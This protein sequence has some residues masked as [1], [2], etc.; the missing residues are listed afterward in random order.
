MNKNLLLTFAIL[1]VSLFA[2]AQDDKELITVEPEVE[3]VDYGFN[4]WSIELDL[5]DSKGAEPYST[6]YFASN[7][8]KFFGGVQLNH[9]GLAARYMVAPKIGMRT[10]L[11]YDM[12]QNQ[13][14]T[15]SK[16]F[17]T[18][19]IQMTFE[20]VV[21]TLR[22]F[23]VQNEAGRFGLLFHLGVEVGYMSPKEGDLSAIGHHEWNGGIVAGLTP[24]YRIFDDVSLFFDFTVNS[25]LRQHFTWNGAWAEGE[26]NLTGKMYTSSL[27]VS[28]GLGKGDV[29]G[30]WAI[31]EDISNKEV[32]ELNNRIGEIEDMMNDT[33]KDGVPDYLDVENNSIA[34][35]AVDTKGR[36]VDKNSNG[37][38]DEFEKFV[39]KTIT[40]NYNSNSNTVND[41]IVEKLINDGYIAAYFDTGKAEPTVASSDNIGF[42]LN[43]LKNNPK[44]SVEIIGYA[45]ETGSDEFN[46]K[47]TGLRAENVKTILVNAG[48][49][50]KRITVIG[51]G[52]DKSVNKKSTYTKNLVRKVRFKIK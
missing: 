25:N 37:I 45:D 13:K 34:G 30:D 3:Y 44:K 33:D 14:G 35:V 43:Y 8:D 20:G 2:N 39:D 41:G 50:P 28:I 22:V 52:T 21:N 36:M 27:G 40:N 32:T 11:S 10:H 26:A 12:L 42:V 46:K 31:I 23:D 24:Q 38:P 48:I 18:E 6:G 29:H 7:P 9:I 17:K 5:G 49:D 47:L 15:D 19:L 51:Q 16:P 1:S 4:R